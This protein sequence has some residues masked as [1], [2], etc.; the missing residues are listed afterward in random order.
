MPA[1]RR[2]DRL[3]IAGERRQG[4]AVLCR[5][6]TTDIKQVESD[7]LAL[8]GVEDARGMADRNCPLVQICLLRTDMERDTNCAEPERFGAYQ[9]FGCQVG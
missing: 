1:D 4:C 7:A 3:H 5:Q 8:A 9:Q 6:A 2:R